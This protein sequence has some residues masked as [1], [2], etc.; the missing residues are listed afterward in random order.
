[1]R[2]MHRLPTFHQPWYANRACGDIGADEVFYCVHNWGCFP[3][4]I[5]PGFMRLTGIVN[6]EQLEG[7]PPEE[8]IGYAVGV[9]P[10][11]LR[12][13]VETL[14]VWTSYEGMESFYKSGIHLEAMKKYGRYLRKGFQVYDCSV[15]GSDLPVAG[16]MPSTQA[17]IRKVKQNFMM[18]IPAR[19]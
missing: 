8:F 5:F 19:R 7:L 15:K 12:P 1:M 17:F 11:S 6:R 18:E 13:S 16:D 10:F 4:Q 3:L 14:T 2:G 9:S